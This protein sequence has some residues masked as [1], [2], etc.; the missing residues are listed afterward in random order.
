MSTTENGTKVQRYEVIL[1]RV[2]KEATTIRE[3]NDRLRELRQQLEASGH[4]AP[5]SV[6]NETTTTIDVAI[7]HVR[8]VF[9]GF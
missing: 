3:A 4:P 7:S 5:A 2:R 8:G 1:N 6:L 9:T